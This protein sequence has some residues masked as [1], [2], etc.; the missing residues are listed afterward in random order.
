MKFRLE[1]FIVT[2]CDAIS[3]TI[4]VEEKALPK[5]MYSSIILVIIGLMPL[6]LALPSLQ[7]YSTALTSVLSKL[8]D[9]Y[10]ESPNVT[11]GVFDQSISPWWE[12]GSIFEVSSVIHCRMRL[13]TT[14]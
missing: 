7:S 10:Y 9:F 2:Y 6:T 14:C 3:L 13:P 5:V 12:S 11:A 1:L 4:S 8:T